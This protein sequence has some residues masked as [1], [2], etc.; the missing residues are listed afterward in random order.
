M[1]NNFFMS[2]TKLVEDS[3]GTPMVIGQGTYGCVHKPPMK[4]KNK[5]RKN[6]KNV[7]KLMTN[8]NAD[9]ELQ[10]YKTISSIDNKKYIYLGKPSKCDVDD[11]ELNRKATIKCKN[12]NLIPTQLD[13]YSLL[14]MK[15]GGK[16]LEQF[17]D[18]VYKN[19]KNTSANKS[20]IEVFWL[21]V[22]RLFYGLKVFHDNE[23]I[24]HDLKQQNIVY[25][26]KQ[27]RLNFIDFGFMTNKSHIINLAKKSNYTLATRYHWSFP[28]DLAFINDNS[29]SYA[30]DTPPS[31]KIFSQYAN[32]IKSNCR[33][34]FKSILPID[35]N[36]NEYRSSVNQ[37]LEK[38]YIMISTLEIKEYDQFLNKSLDTI[39][40]YGLG[41]ALLY[42]L[43]RT[44]K[45]LDNRLFEQL[46][47]L[48][49]NMVSPL[50]Y[51]R[52]NTDELLHQYESIM[53]S[54]GF[55]HKHNKY[56]NNHLIANGKQV[57]TNIQYSIYN[58]SEDGF[59][60]PHNEIIDTEISTKHLC[61]DDKEYKVT[62]KRCVK[63]CKDG[64][65]RDPNFKCV[66]D[67]T[68]KKYK[69]CPKGKQRNPFTNRCVNDCKPGYL[70]DKT[71]KCRKGF[72]PFI[73]I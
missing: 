24:H 43:N 23:I 12:E 35:I 16:N 50:V 30:A 25:D 19:W 34:F 46:G 11:I 6:K 70:R 1:Y 17:A 21:E 49:T 61:P 39:D 10:E 53:I 42:V 20:K 33:Y 48:F 73:S 69:I 2:Q 67:R 54:S 8:D 63:K 31:K 18:D 60:I 55:L 13:K 56:Y 3:L 38:Y 66:K 28:W 58:I 7:S 72:N 62:T 51:N 22:S 36:P 52:Y 71:F 14:I 15:D 40:S 5:T 27:H 57:P 65:T 45:F 26:E 47:F 44:G 29:Y 37:L 64:Y 59:L 32:E 4:C 9:S 68:Q 41:I